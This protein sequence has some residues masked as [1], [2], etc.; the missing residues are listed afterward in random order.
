MDHFNKSL[1]KIQIEPSAS[2]LKNVISS[3]QINVTENW[4]KSPFVAAL[5]KPLIKYN[6]K[7]GDRGN[8]MVYLNDMAEERKQLGIN[9]VGLGW[10]HLVDR[11]G[12]VRWQANGEPK[13]VYFLKTYCI[14]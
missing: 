14:A 6:L 5:L 7:K 11:N 4:L 12:K 10:V 3:I 1:S 8:Y 2:S 13:Q 9:N